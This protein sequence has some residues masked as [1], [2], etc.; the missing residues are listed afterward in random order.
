VEKDI[1]YCP[2]CGTDF[3]QSSGVSDSRS[4]SGYE[5]DNCNEMLEIRVNQFPLAQSR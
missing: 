5:C 1:S 4:S 3:D 2:F